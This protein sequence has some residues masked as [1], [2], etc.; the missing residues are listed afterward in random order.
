MHAVVVFIRWCIQYHNTCDLDAIHV[1]WMAIE[2]SML[3]HVLFEIEGLIMSEE[4]RLVQLSLNQY[5]NVSIKKLCPAYSWRIKHNLYFKVRNSTLLVSEFYT[6]LNV[7]ILEIIS[8]S[9]VNCKLKCKTQ[10][11]VFCKYMY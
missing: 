1:V 10:F 3:I 4:L 5:M 11:L 8:L 9:Y 2:T 7:S 6:F